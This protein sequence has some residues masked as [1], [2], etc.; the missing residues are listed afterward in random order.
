MNTPHIGGQQAPDTITASRLAALQNGYT[1]LPNIDKMCVLEG[2][3]S[4]EVDE[5]EIRRWSRMRSFRATGLRLDNGLC[6]ID[7]DVNHHLVQ[8]L[9]GGLIDAFPELGSAIMRQGRGQKEAWFVRTSE[10]FPRIAGPLFAAPGAEEGDEGHRVEVFGGGSSRQFG[11]IGWHTKDELEYRWV[12]DASPENTPLSSLP[13]FTESQ[14]SQIVAWTTEWLLSRGFTV[15]TAEGAGRTDPEQ[16]WDLNEDTVFM[17]REDG[18]VTLEELRRLIEGQRGGH[19]YCSA[20]FAD[21]PVARNTRRCSVSLDREGGLS[22]WDSMTLL[23]HHEERLRPRS[24][25]EQQEAAEELADT[26]ATQGL[27]EPAA[28]QTNVVPLGELGLYRYIRTAAGTIKPLAANVSHWIGERLPA[29]TIRMNELSFY[30]WVMNDAGGVFSDRNGHGFPRQID[31]LDELHLQRLMNIDME[32]Q[33]GHQIGLEAIRGG[34]WLSAMEDP[35]DPLRDFFDGLEPW[36]GVS[37]TDTW[38]Q[39]YCGVSPDENHSVAYINAVSR[40]WLIAAVRRALEPGVKMD[41]IL[42]LKG[43]PGD[44]RLGKS[45]LLA[46]LAGRYADSPD[47]GLFAD[48]MPPIGSGGGDKSAKEWLRGVWIAEVAE[49]TAISKAD[50]D[51]VKGFISAQQ[52]RFR[53]PYTSKPVTVYRRTIFAATT[54]RDTFLTDRTGNRRFWPVPAKGRVNV[55]GLRRVNRQLW[56]EALHRAMTGEAHWFDV[57]HDAADASLMED[58]RAAQWAATKSDPNVEEVIRTLVHMRDD[59]IKPVLCPNLRDVYR[60]A[61]EGDAKNLPQSARHWME[62]AMQE[63]GWVAHPLS[64][65]KSGKRYMRGPNAEPYVEVEYG[66]NEV[67]THL[68]RKSKSDTTSDKN[69]N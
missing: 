56:S 23:T 40:K 59:P 44:E 57:D 37:R 52:D 45:S 7:F 21:G 12:E 9:Y 16:V 27:T 55:D 3:P 50:V 58:V 51:H 65:K 42:V 35:Y 15:I 43:T 4:V 34:V 25:A 60:R 32:A 68:S 63:A 1:P 49:M 6:A 38:L 13:E 67:A 22:V 11:A 10:P 66:I 19:Y 18:E 14:I 20:S 53:V 33:I 24:E 28:R 48:D 8:E 69:E 61:F 54:N 41:N 31:D 64:P 39:D 62:E 17:T 36:D 47:G 26:L 5:T 2:W 46:A 30:P 29:G